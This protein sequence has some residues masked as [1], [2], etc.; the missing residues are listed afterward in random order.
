MAL[1]LSRHGRIPIDYWHDRDVVEMQDYYHDLSE[2]I[3]AERPDPVE[4]IT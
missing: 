3:R 2:M 4:E 1:A